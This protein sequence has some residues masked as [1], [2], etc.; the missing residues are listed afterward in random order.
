MQYGK[1]IKRNDFCKDER[2]MRLIFIGMPGSGKGTISSLLETK[3][4]W[5]HIS[6]GDILRKEVEKKSDLGKKVSEIMEQGELVSDQLMIEIISKE[7]AEETRGFILDGFPRTVKQ[8]EALKKIISV[9]KVLFLKVEKDEVV[10]R[11]LS[12]SSE[13]QAR[14]DDSKETIEERLRVYEAK[15]QPLL[16]YYKSQK[17]L[18]EVDASK[19]VPLV[20][21]NVEKALGLD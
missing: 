6:T 16:D 15:T 12:R 11:M 20:F 3:K 10:R 14:P 19:P 17:M 5:R 2:I 7:I 1:L 21:S 4:G 8:S 13:G 9:D 18:L